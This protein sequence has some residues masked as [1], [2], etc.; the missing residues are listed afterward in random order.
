M[1]HLQWKQS[2]G[3]NLELNAAYSTIIDGKEPVV[4]VNT[5]FVCFV[6]DETLGV[7]DLSNKTGIKEEVLNNTDL[8]YRAP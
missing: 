8:H 4:L 1:G 2:L 7:K 6:G 3:H 5:N